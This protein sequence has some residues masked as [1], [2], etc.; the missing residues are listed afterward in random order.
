MRVKIPHFASH[1]GVLGRVDFGGQ[2]V[3]IDFEW[4]FGRPS[5]T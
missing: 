3:A 4:L 1:R 2:E 5:L